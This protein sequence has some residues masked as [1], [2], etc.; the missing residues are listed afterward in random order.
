MEDGGAHPNDGRVIVHAMPGL[1]FVDSKI[2]YFG[3]TENDVG[4]G[5]LHRWDVLLRRSACGVKSVQ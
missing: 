5:L 2:L 1:G 3:S 4:I